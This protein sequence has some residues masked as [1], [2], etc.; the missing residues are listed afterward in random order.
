MIP[1]NRPTLGREEEEAAARVVRS[2]WLAQGREVAAFEEEMAAGLGLGSAHAVAFSSGTA[3]LFA[4]LEALGARGR[5]VA[6]PAYVCSAVRHAIRM[7]AGTPVACDNLPGSPNADAAA[8]AAARPDLAVVAHMYGIPADLASLAPIPVIEDC[9]QA[10]GAACDGRPVSLSGA[11]GVFS[12][13]A[14]KTI[15]S[16]GQGGMVVSRDASL[17]A[18]CRDYRQFDQRRDDRDRFNLQMTDLQA[19]IGREQLRK[20]PSF[21]ERRAAIFAAYRER[22]LELLDAPSGGPAC[23]P[24]RYRAVLRT[25]DPA[26]VLRALGAA[27]ATAI[28]PL[29]E[30][31]LLGPPGDF[32]HAAALCRGTVSLPIYPTLDR[33]DVD[34]ILDALESA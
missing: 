13:Y 23:A 9:A 1:H 5:R 28:V 26:R 24:A 14:T 27:G 15:T 12:F 21:L 16:G 11:A 7:A 34:A 18:A 8:M 10:L 25:P 19:A 3:A 32:P 29:E 33:R 17:A 31:E 20:L 2:G 4:A 6:H 22:G 30:W